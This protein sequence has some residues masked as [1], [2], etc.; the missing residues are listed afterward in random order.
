MYAELHPEHVSGLILRGIFLCRQSDLDWIYRDGGLNRFYPD[1]WEDF[2]RPLRDHPRVADPVAAYYDILTGDNELAKM[3]AAKA[4]ALWEAR[5]ATLHPSHDIL[6]QFTDLHNAMA[7]AR[8]E[9]HYFVNRAF[10]AENQILADAHKLRG[11][12]GIIVHGRYDMLCRLDAATAL[13]HL[14]TDSELHIVREAGHA[15][16]EPGITDGLIR[17]TREMARL[18]SDDTESAG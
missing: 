9:S 13:H 18:L 5:C 14:W 6:E 1:Y 11:I 10:I 3:G 17:A 16:A 7:I 8:I 4:W 2:I 12:P 15:A